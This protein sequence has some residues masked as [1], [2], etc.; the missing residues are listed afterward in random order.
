MR[1]QKMVVTIAQG[2]KS[3]RRPCSRYPRYMSLPLLYTRNVLV[4]SCC[5]RDMKTSNLIQLHGAILECVAFCLYEI[6]N[7]RNNCPEN[8]ES[9]AKPCACTRQNMPMETYFATFSYLNCVLVKIYLKSV[10]NYLDE[11]FLENKTVIVCHRLL[12]CF[13][14]TSVACNR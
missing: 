11:V 6:I 7:R 14:R 8:T 9:L 1:R 13:S 4:C 2:E 5:P 3:E 10:L 12:S